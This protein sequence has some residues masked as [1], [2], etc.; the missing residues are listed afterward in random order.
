M[1]KVPE[2]RHGSEEQVDLFPDTEH[3]GSDGSHLAGSSRPRQRD[4]A[5]GGY[6]RHRER[7]HEAQARSALQAAVITA[8]ATP[9]VVL[10]VA[11][12]ASQFLPIYLATSVTVTCTAC[13]ASVTRMLYRASRLSADESRRCGRA[14]ARFDLLSGAALLAGTEE[15]RTELARMLAQ[16]REFSERLASGETTE[17]LEVRRMVEK[18]PRRRAEAP[19]DLSRVA[20]G[21]P[22]VAAKPPR[23]E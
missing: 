6:Q 3:A 19:A 8:S 14:A 2:V 10:A 23:S 20:T 13:W 12:I 21:L 16:D 17:P 18:S 7:Q 22:G 15:A 5:G 1:R 9:I 11:F 4:L